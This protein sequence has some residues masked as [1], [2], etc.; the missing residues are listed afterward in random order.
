MIFKVDKIFAIDTHT[1]T[2]TDKVRRLAVWVLNFSFSIMQQWWQLLFIMACG[3]Y[4]CLLM[5]VVYRGTSQ[6]EVFWYS[7]IFSLGI[8]F[9]I[10]PVM[11]FFGMSIML[12][13][14]TVE[15][16][17]VFWRRWKSA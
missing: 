4:G 14:N 7:S 17:V 12:I 3:G 13:S 15:G 2:I 9:G 16:V 6:G 11:L 1:N 5:S 10:L 8:V